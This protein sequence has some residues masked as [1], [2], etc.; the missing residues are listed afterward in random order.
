MK[1]LI[2]IFITVSLL[3]SVLTGC[4]FIGE[5]SSPSSA[6][7]SSSGGFSSVSGAIDRLTGASAE[8]AVTG[9]YF[10]E[11]WHD[12]IA[13]SDMEYVGYTLDDFTPYAKA[14]SDIARNGGTPDE[15]DDADNS[16]L[17]QLYYLYTQMN[18]A[19]LQY[20]AS[21]Y[22]PE[23]ST[24]NLRISSVYNA[25]YD[26][27]WSAMKELAL[28]DYSSL[29]EEDYEGWQIRWFET[30]E[31]S[32]DEDYGRY[33]RENELVQSYYSL[34]S[35]SEPDYDAIMDVFIELVNLRREQAVSSGYDDFSELAYENYYIRNY[36][37]SDGDALCQAV[38]DSF[39]PLVEKYAYRITQ[40]SDSLYYSDEI[41]CSPEKIISSMAKCLPRMSEELNF[42]FEYMTEYGLYDIDY[43]EDKISTGF[44]TD[45]YY[46][47][48]PFI[49]NCPYNS[50]YDYTDMYHEFGHFVN[51]FYTETDLMF[52]A[53]DNDLAE[54]QSQ[55]M[56]V[57]FLE[58][59]PE[60]FGEENARIILRDELLSLIRSVVD[61]T[62]YDEFQRRIYSEESLT[63]E[64]VT[65][66][67]TEVYEDY[68]FAQYDGYETEW[69]YISHNFDRPFYYISYAISAIAAL[70]LYALSKES[71]SSAM[72]K[73]LT[74]AA[75]DLEVYYYTEAL[76]DAGLGDVF[77][78]AVVHDIASALAPSLK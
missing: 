38:K 77:D 58:F 48:E 72:D 7:G 74:I 35:V 5:N 22:D 12:D 31:P 42:A 53:E 51:A 24:E 59:Y 50:Y 16:A 56:E 71:Y 52:G 23:I 43:S 34:I 47:N 60:I 29:L 68:G 26:L 14:I 13:F 63:A 25:A 69:M 76:E 11:T 65:E 37:P 62:M 55:G 8:P 27:Y 32:S 3:S 2:S 46:Y 39:V 64:R 75:M 19:D 44:T 36:S 17:W 73:F 66:I 6:N 45:L 18:I 9:K 49:F 41:D 33:D 67:Y 4:N 15:F 78:P 1:R 28:S 70:E 54:L 20:S 30:F 57:M 10:A 40:E 61:G 21:P